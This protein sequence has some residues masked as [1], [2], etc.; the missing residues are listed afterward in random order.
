MKWKNQRCNNVKIFVKF[1][2]NRYSI[3]HSVSHDAEIQVS[4]RT[5]AVCCQA[6]HQYEH[7]WTWR[8]Y[9]YILQF[10]MLLHGQQSYCFEFI[11]KFSRRNT[12]RTKRTNQQV[13]HFNR[14]NFKIE[15]I[16]VCISKCWNLMNN[17]DA[18]NVTLNE[19]MWLIRKPTHPCIKWWYFHLKLRFNINHKRILWPENISACCFS[20]EF[21]IVQSSGRM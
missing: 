1:L 20:R 19:E 14:L 18:Q 21:N 4:K 17:I 9:I 5:L 7:W 15:M 10:R 8:L 11:N 6:Q 2:H 3:S 12:S 13:E 16:N